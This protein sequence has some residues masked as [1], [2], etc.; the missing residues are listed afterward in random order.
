MKT[1]ETTDTPGERATPMTAMASF[2]AESG[3]KK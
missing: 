1:E 3:A 2:K